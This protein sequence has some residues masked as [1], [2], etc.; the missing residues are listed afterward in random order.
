MNPTL[1][2]A[3]Q[4]MKRYGVEAE[5]VR[6][7]RLL[8]FE[9]RNTG[10]KKEIAYPSEVEALYGIYDFAERFCGYTFFEPGR[11]VFDAASIVSIPEGTA[12]PQRKAL[13][14]RRGLIQ[15][16][17]FNDETPALFD[18]MAKNKLNYLLVWMKYYDNIPEEFK[19]AAA[20]RGITIESGHH[21]FNYWIPGGKYGKEHPEFLAMLNGKRITPSGTMTELLMSEQL[22]TTNPDLRA[23]IVKNMLEYAEKHPELETL[24]LVPNDGFGWCECPECASLCPPENKGDFYSISEHVPKA[25]TIYH[26][27]IRDVAARL[28]RTRPDLKLSFCAY[29]NYC[30]PSP[31]FTLEPGVMVH[32]APYWRCVNHTIDDPKCPINSGYANDIRAWCACRHGGDVNIYEYFMGVNFYLGLP[33]IHFEEMFHELAWYSKTGVDGILTQFHVPNWTVYGMNYLFMARAARGEQKTETIS[34]LFRRLFGTDEKEAGEFYHALKRLPTE[35]GSCHI[36]Y[37]YSLFSRTGVESYET[38]H[39]I[40]QKLSRKA[41]E[42]RFRQE[43]TI[44]TDY[45]LRFKKLFDDYRRGT[46]SENQL[47]V[48]L[49]WVH[50]YRNTRIFVHD[51]FDWFFDE[52]KRAVR[53]HL[54][55]LHYDIDWEDA[56]I[57]KH[58]KLWRETDSMK[59]NPYPVG[60]SVRD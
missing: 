60:K 9:I 24:S 4:E 12:V 41:P 34:R 17:P 40:A 54:P 36:T 11:D 21:N 26:D 13:L 32:M 53:K 14:K 8:S 47:S 25:G 52:W 55:W 6:E 3:K 2:F 38:L 42:N 43:L 28:H 27:L 58:E 29:I 57:R 15:E 30:A 33:M 7:P 19:R 37:P 39:F 56:Y 51:R 44:W 50:S 16:F 22:C 31:G 45:L 5:L 48:F 59:N 10:G 18:W 49:E 1:E 46:V 23:E 20:L 35:A